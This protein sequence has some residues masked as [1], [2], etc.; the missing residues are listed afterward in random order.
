ML[1]LMYP[2]SRV[3]VGFWPSIDAA[4]LPRQF[5]NVDSPWKLQV[6]YIHIFCLLALLLCQ[7]CK[8]YIIVEQAQL[9]IVICVS[10]VLKSEAS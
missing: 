8:G 2:S 3:N 9:K 1:C 6:L 10:R 7:S 5:Y 4:E